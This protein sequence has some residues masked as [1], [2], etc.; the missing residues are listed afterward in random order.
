MFQVSKSEPKYFISAKTKV[1]LPKIKAAWEDENIASIREMLREDI[2]IKEQNSLCIYCEKKISSDVKKANI[3]HFKTRNLFPEESLIYDNLLVSCNTYNRCSSFKDNHV[4][5]K[6]EYKNIVNPVIDNPEDYFDYLLTGEII[7]KNE[8]G[9]FT[10]ELFALDS[11]VLL[12]TRQQIILSLK[13]F[14]AL[15]LEE[16]Y[17]SFG[18]EYRSFIKAI[19][20]KLKEL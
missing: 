16:I 17:D 9:Q 7:A 14:T 19:Y 8:K 13:Y 5:S 10:I 18:Y 1:K 15:S 3:D 4:K 2:L 6:I 11:K 12:E 20:P